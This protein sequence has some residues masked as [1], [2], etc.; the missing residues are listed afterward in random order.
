MNVGIIGLGIVG[1]SIRLAFGQHCKLFINDKK[2]SKY[3]P[4]SIDDVVKNCGFIFLSVPTPFDNVNNEI[5]TTIIDIVVQSIN[6][7]AIKQSKSPI[8]IVKSAVVP[9]VVRRW[10]SNFTKINII[11]SPEYLTQ[12]DSLH[13]MVNQE[14]MVLGG[15]R[16]LC[17]RVK[18][19]FIENSICNKQCKVAYCTAEEAALVKYMENSFLGLKNIFLNE[20][21]FYYDRYFNN[22][23]HYR[24]NALLDVF[25]TDKRMGILPNNY[26]IPGPDG[27]IGYGGKCLPKDILSI[28]SEGRKIGVE[29]EL[30]EKVNYINNKIRTDKDWEKIEGAMINEV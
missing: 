18:R 11:I 19:L 17:K 24:F 29:F 20:Y 6:E 1:K 9:R 13:D 26:R 28:V 5:E 2:V 22:T 14:V 8:V 23:D 3:A 21:K 4:Y 27:D 12:R 16:N 15:D 30:L 25:H 10:L 7:S